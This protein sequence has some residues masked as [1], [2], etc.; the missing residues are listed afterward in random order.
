MRS[1]YEEL[2]RPGS[3]SL[4][5]ALRLPSQPKHEV[6]TSQRMSLNYMR[7]VEIIRRTNEDLEIFER[8]K[9]KLLSS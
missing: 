4:A 8:L 9:K 3:T 5:Q 1:I 2:G 6:T 7:R